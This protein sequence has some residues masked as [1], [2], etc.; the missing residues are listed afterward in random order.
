M[1]Y[2]SAHQGGGK[3]SIGPARMVMFFSPSPCRAQ[4][5]SDGTGLP[6]SGKEG[7]GEGSRPPR[8]E[9]GSLAD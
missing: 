6:R 7:P 8:R 1:R 2:Y 5:V 3:Q 9:K 4:V